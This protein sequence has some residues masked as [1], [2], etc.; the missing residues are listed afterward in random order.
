MAPFRLKGAV[1]FF[2]GRWDSPTR[3]G[4]SDTFSL[5][6]FGAERSQRAPKHGNSQRSRRSLQPQCTTERDYRR[7]PPPPKSPHGQTSIV[8]S[9]LVFWILQARRLRKPITIF[10]V[11]Q[12]GWSDR[13]LLWLSPRSR[14]LLNKRRWDK[15][16]GRS[17]TFLFEVLLSGRKPQRMNLCQ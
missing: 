9:V 10:C 13:R 12:G 4:R 8:L 14:P 17:D 3:A 16:Q 15:S 1:V 11:V 6:F 7:T 2:L 5:Y